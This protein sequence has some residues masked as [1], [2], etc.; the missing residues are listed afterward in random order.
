MSQRRIA[1]GIWYWLLFNRSLDEGVV[2]D[3]WRSAEI[4]PVPKKPAASTVADHRPIAKLSII[5]KIFE[6]HINQLIWKF[7]SPVI[8][9]F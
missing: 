6:R 2:P 4:V 9:N 7:L 8:S 1:G 3:E 5:S